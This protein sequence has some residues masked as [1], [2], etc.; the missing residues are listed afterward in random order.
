MNEPNEPSAH[1]PEKKSFDL[2]WVIVALL[3]AVL[4]TLLV[5]LCRTLWS[6]TPAPVALI[7]PTRNGGQLIR[8]EMC[9]L[10]SDGTTRLI[11]DRVAVQEA[12]EAFDKYPNDKNGKMLIARLEKAASLPPPHEVIAQIPASKLPNGVTCD[13]WRLARAHEL[14]LGAPK[15]PS[16]K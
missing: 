6:T 8:A 7:D 2:K 4:V 9:T 14:V 10:H 3:F 5:L 12:K 16:M 1:N 13:D 11:S 15:P